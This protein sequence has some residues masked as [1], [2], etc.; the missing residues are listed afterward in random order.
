MS[1]AKRHPFPWVGPLFASLLLGA[2]AFHPQSPAE[3]AEY[4]RGMV[5]NRSLRALSP[6]GVHFSVRCEKN[7]PRAEMTYWREAM[8]TRMSQAGYRILQDTTCSM[9][10]Q[11]GILLK[12]ATPY[13]N[14]DYLYWIAFSLNRA[15]SKIVVAEAAGES[16]RFLARQDAIEKAIAASGFE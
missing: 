5:F 3:F 14:Q 8:K 16:K 9:Q 11:P 6:D 10:G 4:P 2:C 12:L 1:N 7:K 15:G 13:G